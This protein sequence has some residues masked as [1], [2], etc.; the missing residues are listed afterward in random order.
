MHISCPF[1]VYIPSPVCMSSVATLASV[2]SSAYDE[3]LALSVFRHLRSLTY[4]LAVGIIIQGPDN[5]DPQITEPHTYV[6]EQR[7]IE[8]KVVKSFQSV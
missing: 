6:I 8:C 1:F 3:R 2:P 5:V 7:R 4:E